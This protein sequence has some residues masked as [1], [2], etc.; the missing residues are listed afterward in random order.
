[1]VLVIIFILLIIGIPISMVLGITT[2][3]YFLLN[4]QVTFLDSTPL[5]MYS[6]LENFGL[7]AIHL[8]MLMGEIMNEGGIT[9]RLV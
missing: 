7:L 8:F 5:L 4:G 6:G 3:I 1:M 2:V 9:T